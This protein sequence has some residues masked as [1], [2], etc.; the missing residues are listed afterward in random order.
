ML[1]EAF[2][3]LAD[4]MKDPDRPVRLLLS[5]YNPFID[6]PQGTWQ[7]IIASA[8][9]EAGFSQGQVDR[10]RHIVRFPHSGNPR[11]RIDLVAGWLQSV[12]D[13]TA[14]YRAADAGVFPYFA[15]GWNLPLIE[16]MACGT[17]CIATYYSGPTEFLSKRTTS[18]KLIIPG[19]EP[20]KEEM[21]PE[22]NTDIFIPLT[23]GREAVA[24]D[25][26]FFQG[27]RGNWFQVEQNHLVDRMKET[28]EAAPGKIRDIGEN[29][30]SFV[31]SKFTWQQSARA[32]MDTLIERELMR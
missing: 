6:R 11:F 32:A 1:I 21:I 15:E 3:Q 13:V 31:R 9:A 20:Q 19:A 8:L 30:A 7:K 14:L 12:T 10:E 25:N 18:G 22:A 24:R 23:E 28:I 16:A 27:D 4:T 2:G 29:A 26:V 17:P 5:C